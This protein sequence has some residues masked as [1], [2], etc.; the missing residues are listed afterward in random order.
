MIDL[1]T[2]SLKCLDMKNTTIL[3]QI[4]GVNKIKSMTSIHRYSRK[5]LSN[6]LLD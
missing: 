6:S 4:E 1:C 3:Q 2:A 5:C